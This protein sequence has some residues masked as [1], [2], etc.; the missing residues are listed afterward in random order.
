MISI[1]RSGITRATLNKKK[2]LIITNSHYNFKS[3]LCFPECLPGNVGLSCVTKCPYPTYGEKCQGTCDCSKD[4]C[5]VSMGCRKTN[6]RTT[7]IHF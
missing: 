3:V 1:K 5:D 4:A 6:I 2:T 7:G